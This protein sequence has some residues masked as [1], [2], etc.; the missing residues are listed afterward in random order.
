MTS[1]SYASVDVVVI[2]AGFGGLYVL[3]RLR[4]QGLSVRVFETGHRVGG[5][6]FWNRYPGARC[7]L[8]GR[9]YC[10]SFSRE[11]ARAWKW[12]ERYPN[13]SE[14]Q[15]YAELVVDTFG[16]GRDISL[17]TRV[18]SAAYDEE[19][20]RWT[21]RT[22]RGDEVTCRYVVSAV[23]CLSA[24]R[25]PEF[26]GLATYSGRTF[27][28]GRWPREEVDFTGR[29]VAV[30]GTGSSGVQV[31]PEIAARARRLTVYQ[32]TPS[33][34]LPARNRPWPRAEQVDQEDELFDLRQ[35]AKDTKIGVVYLG[36]ESRSALEVTEVERQA[37]FE[38]FWRQGG[39]RFVASFADLGTDLEANAHAAEFVRSKIRETVKDPE[40]ARRL[41]PTDYPIGAKRPCVGTDFYETFNRDNVELVDVREYPITTFS[42]DGITTADGHRRHD[43][44]VFATGYDAMTGAIERIDIRGVGGRTLKEA[45]SAG[46]RTYLGLATHGFP[47]LFFVAGPGSPSVLGNVLA[48]IEQHVEWLGDLL[49]HLESTG[50][51]TVEA[52]IEHQDAWVDEVNAAAAKTLYL[53]T[54]SW[55]MGANVPGKPRVFMPYAGGFDV[56]RQKCDEV[57]RAGYVGFELAPGHRCATESAGERAQAEH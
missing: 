44:I 20:R 51:E 57:A 43:D 38:K 33:Y 7:D 19:R 3:H 45:W 46:P 9:F 39:A 42:V 47:N 55:Y 34:V 24:A 35:R 54:P 6:W 56:Y 11:L 27:H 48:A 40:V 15:E 49:A 50:M 1:V 25:I 10:Y 5:V 23:G 37:Q 26:P 18:E 14:L 21:V 29:D 31:I 8:E 22:D 16:L 30:I 53:T 41:T 32:R 2:G 13:Q 28:T 36:T 52:R 12:T 17:R 4:S